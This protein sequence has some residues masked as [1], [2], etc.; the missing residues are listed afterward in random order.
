MCSK[1]EV[2]ILKNGRVLPFWMPNKATSYAIYEDFSIFPDFQFLS[3]LGRSK[4]VLVSLFA[5]LAKI[6]PKNMYRTIQSQNFKFDVFEI[7][8]F[9]NL[10][11]AKGHKRLWEV[12]RG[13]PNTIHVF[14]R[15]ISIWYGCFAGEAN[16]D[17]KSRILPLTRPVMSSMTSQIFIATYSKTSSS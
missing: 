11:L 16:M 13:I 14:P 9:D 6:W 12:L 8:T 5:F 15:L 17:R 7:L 2:A 3:Y 1:N 4:F 10:H